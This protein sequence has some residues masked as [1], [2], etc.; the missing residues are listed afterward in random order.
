MYIDE[1]LDQAEEYERKDPVVVA[2]VGGGRVAVVLADL[3]KCRYECLCILSCDN[4]WKVCT[5]CLGMVGRLSG[6]NSHCLCL[7]VVFVVVSSVFQRC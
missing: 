3:D 7:L 2:V 4:I 1:G 5:T 6:P